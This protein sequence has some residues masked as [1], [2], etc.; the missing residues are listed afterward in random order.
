MA[1]E[2]F[3]AKFR[4][5]KN[6][7]IDLVEQKTDRIVSLNSRAVSPQQRSAVE[8]WIKPGQ[9]IYCEI[10]S[11]SGGHIIERASRNSGACYIGFEL[12]FKRAFRTV[13]KA[14]AR[15][16]PNVFLIRADAVTLPEF[17]SP[18]SL[19]G[20]YINFPDPWAKAKWKKNRIL[21]PGFLEKISVLLKPGGFFAY[22]TDHT[23][24]FEETVALLRKMPIFS[25]KELTS[26]LYSSSL[27]ADN[28]PSEFENLFISQGLKISCVQAIK[29]GNEP[30][31]AL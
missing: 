30:R 8:A 2:S 4:N 20:V 13:Q 26:D 31:S 28:V 18:D 11:G 15:Q 3:G 16:V 22:K 5:W 10:G 9:P 1:E 24:Y 17:F 29:L 21:N 19:S 25:I 23:E 6:Q 7:Y 12:R 14:E 27:L